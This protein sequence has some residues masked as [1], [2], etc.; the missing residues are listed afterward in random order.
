MAHYRGL[1]ADTV[2]IGGG[3]PTCLDAE[4]LTGLLRAI[5]NCFL[6]TDT[7]EI[8]VECNPK[9]VD[10]IYLKKLHSAGVNRLSVGVQSFCD[11]QSELLGRLHNAEEA[12]KCIKLAQDCGFENINLDLMFGLPYQTKEVFLESL[13]TA[14]LLEPTHISAYSLIL[15]EGTLL[16]KRVE[17]GELQLPDEEMERDLY[18]FLIKRLAQDGYI[19]YEISNFARNGYESKHNNK[20]WE[21]RPYIGL[22]A[23]AHSQFGNIRFGNPPQLD[24]YEQL[25][26]M[27]PP[28]GRETEL[29]T[30]TDEM[31]EFVFLG[32]RKVRGICKSDFSSK[33]ATEIETVYGSQLTKF[34]KLGLLE[35]HGNN[36]CLT[37]KG[38]DVSNSIFCEFLPEEKV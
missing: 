11:R 37:E 17:S 6:L 21:R 31:A 30:R 27:I 29:L 12:K 24:R 36:I 25:V 7:C 1:C 34:R 5:Q 14:L 15:E 20:Y 9:T 35:E 23:A 32:L 38:I 2:Y 8:T 26:Q 33:F 22:G 10:D 13:E 18:H 28:C 3:T 19:H 4:L 16:A